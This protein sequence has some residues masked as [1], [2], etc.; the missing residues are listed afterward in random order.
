MF[1]KKAYHRV[2][3]LPLLL[4]IRNM[5]LNVIA[6]TIAINPNSKDKGIRAKG[7]TSIPSGA[8]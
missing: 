4:L 8:T 5:I 7:S 3:F 2:L 1:F 6:D